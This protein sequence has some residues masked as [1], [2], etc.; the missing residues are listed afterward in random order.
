MKWTSTSLAGA[1]RAMLLASALSITAP[2][3]W[4]QSL[5]GDAFS[6]TDSLDSPPSGEIAPPSWQ[7]RPY[8]IR[9]HDGPAF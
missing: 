1:L 9:S 8:A 6:L 3:A 4:A 7:G 2:Q 5:I